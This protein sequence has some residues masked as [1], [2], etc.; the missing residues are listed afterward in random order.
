MGWVKSRRNGLIRLRLKVAAKVR[1]GWS[2]SVWRAVL[3]VS[4]R[5]FFALRWRSVGGYVSF[6]RKSPLNWTTPSAMD[7]A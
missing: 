7:V 2:N 5:S 6:R 1:S 3:P 4:F